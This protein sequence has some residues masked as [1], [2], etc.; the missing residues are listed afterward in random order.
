[1]KVGKV[2]S[3][4]YSQIKVKISSEIKGSSVNLHGDV[5]YF[6][7]IGSYLK[8]HNAVDEAIICE[9][10]AIF[11]S[12]IH[13][14]KQSFNV[15]SNREL[16]LKPIGTINKK[17]G[18]ALGV[19]IFPSLYSDVSIVTYDDMNTILTDNIAEDELSKDKGKVHT[20]FYLGQS[21]NLIN[22]KISVGIDRFFNI[23]SAVLGNSGS[24]KSNS[25][26]HIIQQIHAKED[27]AAKGSRIL[28]FDVSGEYTNAFPGSNEFLNVK[29]FKP[30]IPESITI[31]S[32]NGSITIQPFFMPHFLMSLDEWSAFLMAADAS[33]RPFWDK[34]LQESYRFYK[35]GYSTDIEKEKFVNYLRH[36]ICVI[37]NSILSQA[38][39][40]TSR[41]TT[42]AGVLANVL[43]IIN[44]DDKIISAATDLTSDIK[45]LQSAC[46][47]DFG[48]NNN[49]LQNAINEIKKNVDVV[50]ANE[51]AANKIKSNEYFNYEFLKIAAE[52]ILL[53]E[54]ARGNRQIRGYTATML[55]RLDFFLDNHRL[56][57]S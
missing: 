30:N 27:F 36:R 54:D 51:V 9:V 25:I 6:G 4:N 39:T 53:E 23:H 46:T 50:S 15:E 41:I 52:L 40:D 42:A 2:T 34:V 5:Y 3:V 45:R 32:D 10:I 43:S 22:Y 38:D 7:N 44:S 13:L 1:M 26:A 35:V 14:E 48:K 24:G 20:S 28:I 19:G 16:L 12:D 11:D 49:K 17:I 33:Q 21:K 56:P 31:K 37:I 47:L 57:L 55:T 18:F 29:Y 8:V